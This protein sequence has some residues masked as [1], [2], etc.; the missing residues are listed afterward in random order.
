M[1]KVSIALGITVVIVLIAGLSAYW[2]TAF[3]ANR[4]NAE[5]SR[6]A[7]T[8]RTNLERHSQ[9]SPVA[10]PGVYKDYEESLVANSKGQTL[11]F[12]HAPWC[13]QCRIIESDITN[14]GLPNNVTVLKVDYDSNNEL[15]KKYEVT[16]Q[17]TFIKVD[18]S[19]N[20]VKKYVAYNEP[21]FKSVSEHLLK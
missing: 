9:S 3:E 12:F 19:G 10:E 8:Q 15:R 16:L 7:A 2:L 21:T 18:N 5:S 13:P 6:T 1:K 20:E 17:T 4:Q 14:N 11:L